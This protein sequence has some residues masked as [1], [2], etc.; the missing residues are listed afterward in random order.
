MKKLREDWLAEN[1]DARE[2]GVTKWQLNNQISHAKLKAEKDPKDFD[3]LLD[4]ADAYGI[5]DPADKRCLNV[6]DR[7][8]KAGGVNTLDTQRQGEAYQLYGRCLFLADR[9]ED[10]LEALKK[11]NVCFREKG[12]FTLRRSNNRALLRVLCS[13]GRGREASERLEVALTL[14]ENS[15]DCVMLYISAKQA[16]EHTS[17]DRDKEVLD[18]IWF[19]FLDTHP[20]EKAKFEQYSHTGTSLIR[21]V[22][23]G[24]ER[25]EEAPV[26]WNEV[27]QRLKDPEVWREIIP[28]AVE[29]VKKNAWMKGL[30]MMSGYMLVMYIFLMCIAKKAS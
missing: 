1:S 15:D 11:A 27:W 24:E 18:D 8:V 17:C 12:N 6:C 21:Q 19:V 30:F 2:E 29:E 9:L 28:G 26:N 13:L 4:L 16:L 3:K 7:L 20:D 10:S 14:C 23:G 25:H 5:L 22:G